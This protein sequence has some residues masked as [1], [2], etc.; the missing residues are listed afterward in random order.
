MTLSSFG[1]ALRRSWLPAL[2][3]LEACIFGSLVYARQTIQSTA[4][5]TVA[6]RD[7]VTVRPGYEAAQITFDA[8]VS[9]RR[10]S[11]RVAGRLGETV[12][13]V[14]SSLSIKII[15]PAAGFNISPL[16]AVRGDKPTESEAIR[17]VNV[18]VEEARELYVELNDTKT[19]DVTATLASERAA[20]EQKKV[21]SQAAYDNFAA[22][23]DTRD[24]K[25][26]LDSEVA[27]A[28]TLE[29]QVVSSRADLAATRSVPS[30]Q[31][32][33]RALEQRLN[34]FER[35]LAVAVQERDR[36]RGLASRNDDLVRELDR[37]KARVDQLNDL[38][39]QTVL[40]QILPLKSQVKVLDDARIQSQTLMLVLIYGVGVILGLLAAATAVYVRSL[41]DAKTETPETI[42]MA[43]GAPVLIRIPAGSLRKGLR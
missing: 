21:E 6:V 37:A 10:L 34:E 22:E 13:A 41:A 12:D 36:L 11:E 23:N 42:S 20:A 7:P 28:R 9:S 31:A 2:L 29:A 39:K 1:R 30:N 15:P 19:E 40:S 43:F 5:A 27:R 24:L 4:Q 25:V 17:L 26:R 14:E 18:A 16:Y 38:E 35:Q 8:V 33:V 3:L 32:A